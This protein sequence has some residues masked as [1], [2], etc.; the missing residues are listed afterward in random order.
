MNH[1]D[2][3]LGGVFMSA[4]Y[5]AAF[6]ETDPRR[7]VEA[8][9]ATLP[10]ESPYA[11][12]LRDVLEWSRQ[13][14]DD[15]TRVWRLINDKWDQREPCPAGALR[16]FNIDAKLNGAY[17]AL[18]LLYGNGDFHKTIEIATRG[19]QDSDCNPASAAGVLGVAL[20]FE[21]IPQQYK[22]GTAA[23]ADERFSYTGYTLNTIVAS[24]L[25]RAIALVER[26]GGRLEGDSVRVRTQAFQPTALETWDDYGSPAERV[27]VN[28]AR[29]TFSGHWERQRPAPRSGME[30]L[31]WTRAGGAEASI[32]FEGTGA[33][34]AG[35]YLPSGGTADVYLDGK[36][37][38]TVDVY[39]DEETSRSEEAVWH[40]FRLQPGTHRL[41]VVARGEPYRA[42]SGQASSG[43]DVSL[44]YLLVFR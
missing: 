19:G 9:L 40:A 27:P 18:G 1:G 43:A 42:P 22:S 39:S 11:R 32:T 5:S 16:P 17:V 14:P 15:W 4:M 6:F 33:I 10:P 23:I 37:H 26:H 30:S 36:L 2:G 8:G 24:S 25:R 31:R 29:W 13:F 35:T 20:G 41:R 28:D 44:S 12:V 34:L 7:I 3:I 38:R 21:G